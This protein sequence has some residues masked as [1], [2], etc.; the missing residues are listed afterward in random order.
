ML[1]RVR[2]QNVR[3]FLLKM[4]AVL[5]SICAWFHTNNDRQDR[6]LYKTNARQGSLTKCA[7]FC[8][9]NVHNFILQ[10]C[11]LLYS[12]CAQ[13]SAG[14][15]RQ[16]SKFYT[17]NACQDSL[18]KCAQFY[19]PNVRVLYSKY[20]QFCT[21][22]DRQGPKLPGFYYQ[23]CA[24]YKKNVRKGLPTKRALFFIENKRSKFCADFYVRYAQ[25]VVLKTGAVL[26]AT[27][28]HFS[29]YNVRSFFC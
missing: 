17:T 16:G 1:A 12:K 26:Y 2:S 6:K 8:I 28:R 9:Q 7:Q 15:D 25:R 14:H 24:V 11:A 5:Y 20:A 21:E 13:V 3:S 19:T 18:S 22:N 23:I 4:C 10:I 27:Y 29:I